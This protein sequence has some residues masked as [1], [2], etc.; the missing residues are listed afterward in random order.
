MSKS[1]RVTFI[2][3]LSILAAGLTALFVLLIKNDN[4]FFI[5][6]FL[7]KESEELIIDQT[8][9][10]VYD[11]LTI[12]SEEGNIYIKHSDTEDIKV[13]I[14]GKE[15]NSSVKAD[16]NTLYIKG[17]TEKCSFFCFNHE[18]A[19]I[20]VYIPINYD[21]EIN[22]D[23]KTGDIKMES[24]SS[25]LSNINTSTGD[26]TIEELKDLNIKTRTGDIKAK[27]IENADIKVTTG[28]ININEI[29]SVKIDST[30]GDINIKKVNYYLDINS[31]TGDVEIK[32]IELYQNSNIDTTTGDVEI[33][34]TNEL[35]FNT[36]S[37]TGDIDINNNNRTAELELKI[38]TTT[39]DITI[40]N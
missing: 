19:R 36:S 21:K 10:N 37:S 32:E 28:D 27:K 23:T 31:T 24:F 39:G 15:E 4:S 26:I 1:L 34:E 17:D 6:N 5:F 7:S 20:E 38:K 3:I 11:N 22:I 2:V 18:Y 8:F 13:K 9:E 12:E 25:A 33:G 35:Y 29:S 16:G 30:T 40:D 14:F